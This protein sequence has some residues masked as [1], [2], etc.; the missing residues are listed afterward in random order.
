MIY[1]SCYINPSFLYFEECIVFV[2]S[3]I[4]LLFVPINCIMSL[5]LPDLLSGNGYCRSE[6]V[7]AIYIQKAKC[8]RRIY[9]TLVH[10]KNNCDGNKQQG[11]SFV[12]LAE[13]VS[14]MLPDIPIALL[15]AY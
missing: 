8:A 5:M 9:A 12:E 10:S 11:M 1:F 14:A 6:A 7:V 13:C 4:K 15:S 3:C 2:A